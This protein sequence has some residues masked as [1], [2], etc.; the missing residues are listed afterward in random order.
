MAISEV[1]FLG[2]S[3]SFHTISTNYKLTITVDIKKINNAAQEIKLGEGGSE[4][5]LAN[6]S[7]LP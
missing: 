5:C 1:E 6:F 2:I 3:G 7:G 4:Q